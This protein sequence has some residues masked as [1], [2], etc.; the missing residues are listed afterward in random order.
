M[1]V[2]N[3]MVIKKFSTKKGRKGMRVT[4]KTAPK[5]NRIIRRGRRD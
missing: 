1:R 5:K 4:R 2:K 3:N